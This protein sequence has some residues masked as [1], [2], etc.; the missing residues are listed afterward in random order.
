MKRNIGRIAVCSALFVGASLVG[1]AA[2]AGSRVEVE[3]GRLSE[4]GVG[5]DRGY[6]IKGPVRLKVGDD[7]T[8]VRVNVTGL[9]S[10][11]TYSS[12]LHDSACSI[13][14][15]GGHYKDDP[16]GAV[17]PPNELWLSFETDHQGNAR[18]V[19]TAP[20]VVRDGARSVV[21][22]DADGARIA[23]ADLTVG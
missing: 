1:G 20:W 8:Q 15:G 21:I 11:S 9:A 16:A 12:H 3:R 18:D 13:A 17:T 7:W 22:H 19:S 4:Y 10:E 14:A 23:C 6:D 2:G 5:V